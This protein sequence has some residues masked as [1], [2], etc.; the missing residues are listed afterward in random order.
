MGKY[1][2]DF[3]ISPGVK[4]SNEQEHSLEILL[5]VVPITVLKSMD[6]EL[7]NTLMEYLGLDSRDFTKLEYR[8]ASITLGCREPEIPSIRYLW[9]VFGTLQEWRTVTFQAVYSR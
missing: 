1:F 7:A 2:I 9:V 4:D 6:V 8:L 5:R 3:F